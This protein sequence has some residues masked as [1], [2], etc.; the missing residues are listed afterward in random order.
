MEGGRGINGGAVHV[1]SGAS[2]ADCPVSPCFLFNSFVSCA[3]VALL[4]EYRDIYML[5]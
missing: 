3:L 2:L 5:Y 1:S 4:V